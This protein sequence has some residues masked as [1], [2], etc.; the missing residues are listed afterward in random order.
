[1]DGIEPKIARLLKIPGILNWARQNFPRTDQTERAL[2]KLADA[3][4]T[5]SLGPIYGLCAKLAHRELSFDEAIEK[6]SGYK[7]FYREAAMEILP[8]FNEYVIKNQDEGVQ[9]FR[10][11][12]VPFPIGRSAEGKVSAIP[13]RPTFVTIRQGRLHPV[14]VLGWI[15]SPLTVHQCRLVSAIVKRALL[16]QHDFAGSDAEVVT[17]PRYKREKRRYQGGWLI[18]SF[19]DLTD[20]ELVKQFDRYNLALSRVIERL[21]GPKE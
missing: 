15:D 5:I 1:M 13:V 16:T 8:L 19:S 2:Q 10:R 12:R 18:S 14:F 6:A 20:D 17:F 21:S 9:D 3:D 11:L 7:R 4:I